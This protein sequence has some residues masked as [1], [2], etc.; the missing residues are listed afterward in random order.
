MNLPR[1][2]S[3]QNRAFAVLLIPLFLLSGCSVFL[4]AHTHS[5][6]S[7]GEQVIVRMLS[8]AELQTNKAFKAD[9]KEAFSVEL[10][11]APA[12]KKV[13]PLIAAAAATAIV[14]FAV[15]Y[16]QKEFTNEAT[17]YQAQFG[18]TIVEDNFWLGPTPTATTTDLTS[19][20]HTVKRENATHGDASKG[21]N[22]TT[23]ETLVDETVFT[24]EEVAK[25]SEG[26]QN[27]GGFEISRDVEIKGCEKEAFHLICGIAP[28]ADGQMLRIAPLQFRTSY[29]KAK[30]LSDQWGW[31]FL[32]TAWI[33]KLFRTTGHE[34][35]TEV[36]VEIDAYWKGKD[37]TMNI[38]KV[39][40]FDM[41]FPSYDIAAQKFLRRSV[42]R[43]KAPET[44]ADRISTAKQPQ[45][46][47]PR[48]SSKSKRA[49]EFQNDIPNEAHLSTPA[50]GWLVGLPRSYDASGQ[51]VGTG[52]FSLKALVTERD[53]SN[54]KKY[55]EE[56][57]KLIAESKSKV[58]DAVKKAVSP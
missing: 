53:K 8:I 13:V 47:N 6:Q 20:K 34:I 21:D 39:A 5:D 54:A 19:Q 31:W 16:V 27:Y 28:S 24:K 17:R 38:T 51:L 43:E 36:N 3:R 32:P 52:T 14:G 46:G 45:V 23:N 30:V 33:G 15:D 1:N 4:P 58:T 26:K 44:D 49:G 18:S 41:K 56:A 42:R 55:L 57:G 50:S 37:Q 2:N 11:K 25:F 48:D 40:G 7:K 10:P 22:W 29:S 9:Y 12:Q 35:D